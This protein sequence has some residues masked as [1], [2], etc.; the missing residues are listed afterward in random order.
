[1]SLH[2]TPGEDPAVL[3]AR[4]A[5]LFVDLRELPEQDATRRQLRDRLVELHLPLVE[6]LARRFTGRN[7][8]L[9]DLVQVGVIGLLK[10]IDRF[11][12]DRGL[13]FSTYA[14][15]TILGE[16]KRHFRDAGWLL[17]VP[18]RAQELQASLTRARDELSQQLHRAPTVAELAARL[19]VPEDEVIEALDVA[20]AYAGVPLEVLTEREGTPID[21]PLLSEV[22]EAL[23]RVEQRAVLRPAIDALTDREREVLLLRF[24]VGKS[25][26]EIADIIGVSQMQVSRLVA[27]SLARLRTELAPAATRPARDR[28]PRGP[29]A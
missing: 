23:E 18:R 6:Y 11:D 7:E 8:P 21:S 15:P 2:D 14:T 27:R 1:M 29:A 9:P 25:Q 20:R 17:H 5:H 4:A 24:I 22:D 10:S 16:I 12:P 26:T 3:R 19:T 13:E 28:A